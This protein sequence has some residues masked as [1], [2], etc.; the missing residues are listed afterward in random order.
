MHVAFV[1]R[2]LAQMKVKMPKPGTARPVMTRAEFIKAKETIE[3]A[4]AKFKL[5]L[6]EARMAVAK[7]NTTILAAQAA[8][9]RKA[10]EAQAAEAARLAAAGAPALTDHIVPSQ[11]TLKNM[12]KAARSRMLARKLAAAKPG[13]V[14]GAIGS[15][16]LA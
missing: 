12:A 2:Y 1:Q 15:P 13:A 3:E 6:V 11:A 8:T 4:K 5:R 14:A 10:A 16:I 9:K 7:R